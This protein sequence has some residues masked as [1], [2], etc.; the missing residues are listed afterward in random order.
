LDVGVGF[1][2]EI[3]DGPCPSSSSSSSSSGS[4]GEEEC[5]I[6]LLTYIG[7]N[8]EY[9]KSSVEMYG[10]RMPY[11]DAADMYPNMFGFDPDYSICVFP[12]EDYTSNVFGHIFVQGDYIRLQT[13]QARHQIPY[14]YA[15]YE[16]DVI[17]GGCPSGSSSSSD[18]SS[19]LSSDSSSSSSISSSS[20]SSSSSSGSSRD[21]SSSSM[22]GSSSAGSSGS[23][24]VISSGSSSV[25]SG[26][27]SSSISSSSSSSGASSGSPS[28]SSS[29]ASSG[30]SSGSLSGGSSGGSVG[31][32]SGSSL[33][34]CTPD[35]ITISWS[36]I[37]FST[38]PSTTR[39]Y[40]ETLTRSSCTFYYR[41][42]PKGECVY[43]P[44]IPGIEYI[45]VQ[46]DGSSWNAF[47]GENCFASQA[48]A[49]GGTDPCDPTGTYQ[50]YYYGNPTGGTWTIS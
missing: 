15:G 12:F 14:Q 6:C 17:I 49:Y 44:G 33:G 21:S 47:G 36:Y 32:D 22:S 20:D 8:R 40:T 2:L 19:G 11:S 45:G 13:D 9:L 1:D 24:S 50:E 5:K 34:C 26:S 35:T 48:E 46:Y 43:Y 10:T 4:S 41:E 30:A 25:S 31:S 16:Y 42:T 39:S 37:D 29:G 18:S 3:S 7:L 23:S 38:Y 27:S 28:G